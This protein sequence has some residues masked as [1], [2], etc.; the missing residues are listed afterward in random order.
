MCIKPSL[1]CHYPLEFSI[2]NLKKL[3]G[4]SKNQLTF[5]QV[6]ATLYNISVILNAK[7]CINFPI[8]PNIAITLKCTS[9]LTEPIIVVTL[10]SIG[11]LTEPII[12]VTLK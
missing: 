2:F 1:T 6:L 7:P 12:I 5:I 8:K 11:F 4:I 10:K 3:I 9:F